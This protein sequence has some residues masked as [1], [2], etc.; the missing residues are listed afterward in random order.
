MVLETCTDASLFCQFVRVLLDNGTL[1]SG[2]IFIVDNCS[3][4]VQGDNIGLQEELFHTHGILMITLPPY[5]PDY[6]PTELVFN[7]LLQRIS[8]Q[9]AR[10][11]SLAADD[12][13]DAICIELDSFTRHDVVG[14]F[15]HCGYDK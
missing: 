5:H 11:K 12:F 14:F 7:T 10:Y 2:D 1:N 13:L 6:N 15:R 8:A 9:R 4:H 3:I